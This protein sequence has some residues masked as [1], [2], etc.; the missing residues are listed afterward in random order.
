MLVEN[1][2]HA[3]YKNDLERLLEQK[4]NALLR[5]GKDYARMTRIAGEAS[6]LLYALGR[7]AELM[8]LDPEQTP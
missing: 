4:V 2:L 1:P 6:A 3:A 7:P 8:K 5:P